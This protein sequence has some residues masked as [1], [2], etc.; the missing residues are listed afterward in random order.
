ME[1]GVESVELV[2]RWPLNIEY[3]PLI[4]LVAYCS[5]P[6]DYPLYFS[7]PP[8]VGAPSVYAQFT[9]KCLCLLVLSEQ[10]MHGA[11]ADKLPLQQM[12][13]LAS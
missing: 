9:V 10:F 8:V 4:S 12:V 7:F 1:T 5:P 13:V 6:P 2:Y 11:L 3:S